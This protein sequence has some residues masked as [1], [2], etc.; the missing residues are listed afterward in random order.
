VPES[1]PS[2]KGYW[3]GLGIAIGAGIGVALGSIA[4]GAG[5]GVA[6]GAALEHTRRDQGGR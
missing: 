5:I 1:K 3:L 2:R 4:I 6:L